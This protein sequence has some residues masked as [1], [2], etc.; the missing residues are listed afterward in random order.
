MG[1]QW[2]RGKRKFSDFNKLMSSGGTMN[3]LSMGGHVA[4]DLVDA[5]I[6]FPI[7]LPTSLPRWYLTLSNHF[8][9]ASTRS[10]VKSRDI[11]E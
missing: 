1:H 6:T 9:L 11:V 8:H 5:L 4:D 7:I 10:F 3:N 2:R